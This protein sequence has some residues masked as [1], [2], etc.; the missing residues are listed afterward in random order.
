MLTCVRA[1]W[2]AA[3]VSI[4]VERRLFQAAVDFSSTEYFCFSLYILNR[5]QMRAISYHS[6]IGFFVCAT[7]AT[8]AMLFVCAALCATLCNTK[9]VYAVIVTDAA[10]YQE[11]NKSL[12]KSIDEPQYVF[13]NI[14]I[15]MAN[16][17]VV[18]TL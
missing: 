15:Y 5:Q 17:C 6:S 16:A 2:P 13:L 11:V 3:A 7:I 8:C 9:F 14:A 4:S 10:R 12:S 18:Q 1:W